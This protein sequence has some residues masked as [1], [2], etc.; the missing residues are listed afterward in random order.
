M[1]S[2][3]Y[4]KKEEGVGNRHYFFILKG[5]LNDTQPNGFFNEFLREDLMKHKRVF[6]ALGSKMR[7][8]MSDAQLS[9][10]GFS[11]T[12]RNSVICR[13]SGNVTRVVRVNF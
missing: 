2:P 8:E 6:E 7:V 9:G 4:W 11:S 5:C 12:K 1:Y 3:N 13:L 10:V